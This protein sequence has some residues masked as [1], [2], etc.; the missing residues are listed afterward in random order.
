MNPPRET[1]HATGTQPAKDVPAEVRDNE[2]RLSALIQATTAVLWTADAQGGFVVPQ[3]SWE[4]YTG[5]RWPEYAG[6]GGLAAIHPEDRPSVEEAWLAGVRSGQPYQV[7]ARLWH[8]AGGQYRHIVCRAAPV[9]NPD[10][11]IREWVGTFEDFHQRWLA[12][13]NLRQSNAALRESEDHFRHTVELNPQIPWTATPE[14]K[15]EDFSP[16]WLALT[17]LTREQAFMGGWLQAPHPEDLPGLRE[18]WAHSIRTGEPF[19]L[20]H[21][22]RSAD[23]IYRWVRTRARPRR[24]SNGKIV[25]WYAYTEDIDDRKR[26]EIELRRAKRQ[27]DNILA[28]I[29]ESFIALDHQWRFTYVSDRVLAQTEKSREQLIGQKLW[30]V[31]PEARESGFWDGY[32]R[33]MQERVPVQFETIYPDMGRFFEVHA[34]PTDEGICAYILDITDRKQ[35]EDALRKANAELEEFAHVASHDL[36]EPLRAVHIFTELLLKRFPVE[37]TDASLYGGFIR[38]AV[39]RMVDLIRDLLSYSKII[40]ADPSLRSTAD[41]SSSLAQA[42]QALQARIDETGAIVTSDPLPLV[43]GDSA[44]LSQ[45]FQNLLSNSLKYR[46]D[47]LPPEIHIAAEPEREHWVIAVRDNGIGFEQQYA[48]RIFRLF[49]R[50]HR[51]QYPGTGLGLAIC[52]RIVQRCGGRMWAE[53]KPGE[54]ATFFFSLPKAEGSGAASPL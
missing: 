1:V 33:C 30:D 3:P 39:V 26:A 52:Q 2:Q 31:F 25:R 48:E 12:E 45:V 36:Q 41:L 22:L 23:G 4:N 8:A 47:P 29:R 43:L 53:S 40:H 42:L 37:D 24:D 10:Y 54:G 49:Q 35:N 50:L 13:E 51:D 9:R 11:S 38:Q 17:G 28:S 27:V 18:R 14:G 19:D 7:E 21:R 34:Y 15:L 46:R 44:L 20:E 6:T 5:Q 16:Q 32:H